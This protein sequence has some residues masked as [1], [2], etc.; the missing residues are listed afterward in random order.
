MGDEHDHYRLACAIA[1]RHPPHTVSA[2]RRRPHASWLLAGGADL[3]VVKER[4]GHASITTTEKYLHTLPDT[5]DAALDA[6]NN[7]R[8]PTPTSHS[9]S[10][11]CQE[12]ARPC[13][14]SDAGGGR[15]RPPRACSPGPGQCD[16]EPGPHHR[17][18]APDRDPAA[19]PAHPAARVARCRRRQPWRGDLT[20]TPGTGTRPGLPAHGWSAVGAQAPTPPAHACLPESPG[21]LSGAG[22]RNHDM[23]AHLR[24]RPPRAAEPARRCLRGQIDQVESPRVV[25]GRPGPVRP[26][27]VASTTCGGHR[28]ILL[29]TFRS[30]LEGDLRDDRRA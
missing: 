3:Q 12:P 16:P 4:L 1:T 11:A 18:T 8:K 30:A 29:G 26:V 23:K 2:D 24:T 17:Q 27:R 14:Q 21:S 28:V 10:S 13:R 19:S 25:Y 6:L 15:T 7:I 5:D 22:G 9:P 20:T